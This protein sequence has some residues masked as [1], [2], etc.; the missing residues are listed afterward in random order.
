M[1]LLSKKV[2]LESL[3]FYGSD[4]ARKHRGQVNGG[5]IL[6]VV[7]LEG[8]VKIPQSLEVT[9]WGCAEISQGAPINHP[10]GEEVT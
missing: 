6:V 4:S 3:G 8:C 9:N 1:V 5:G 7:G 2:T 10:A